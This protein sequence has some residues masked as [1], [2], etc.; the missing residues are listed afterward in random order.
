MKNLLHSAYLVARLRR[1]GTFTLEIYS[2]A[3]P[4]RV[5]DS[6]STAVV[7]EASCTTSFHDA[8]VRLVKEIKRGKWGAWIAPFMRERGT[9]EPPLP[10]LV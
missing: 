10:R 1:D 5:D 6:S 3:V 4:T 8:R 2:E 9:L 7:G